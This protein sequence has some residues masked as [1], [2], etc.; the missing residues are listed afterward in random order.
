MVLRCLGAT[1]H[2]SAFIDQVLFLFLSQFTF[3]KFH[4]P[5]SDLLETKGL[6]W[7]G[8]LNVG[9]YGALI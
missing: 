8:I 3:L 5:G 1:N 7:A 9:S 2:V 6:V 4:F